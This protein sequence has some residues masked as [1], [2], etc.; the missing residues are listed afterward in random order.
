MLQRPTHCQ[1]RS[2]RTRARAPP[3][4][5]PHASGLP[6]PK[7]HFPAGTHTPARGHAQLHAAGLQRDISGTRRTETQNGRGGRGET[8]PDPAPPL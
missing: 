4:G 7:S 5:H 2:G 3:G 8:R 1:R 6:L